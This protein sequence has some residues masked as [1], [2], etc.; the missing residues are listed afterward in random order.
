MGN[1]SKSNSG[2]KFDKLYKRVASMEIGLA[3]CAIRNEALI[4]CLMEQNQVTQEDFA[5]KIKEI[6]R[7]VYGV[8][9][10]TP[11]EAAAA[12]ENKANETAELD[13]AA[14]DTSEDADCY[15]CESDPSLIIKEVK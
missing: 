11:E 12:V 13:A 10:N 15:Q 4:R 14:S 7:A 8:D 2:D 5:V 1:K 6:T 3:Q 9:I